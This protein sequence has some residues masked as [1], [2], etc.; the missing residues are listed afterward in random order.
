MNYQSSDYLSVVDLFIVAC[1]THNKLH[2]LRQSSVLFP[3]RE[4]ATKNNLLP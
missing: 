1:L 2:R 3:N 4:Q